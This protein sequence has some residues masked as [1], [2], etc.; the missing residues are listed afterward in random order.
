MAFQIPE[1]K[2][3]IKQNRFEFTLP[4]GTTASMPKAKYLTIGQVERLSKLGTEMALT[5]MLELFEE[6][7]ALEAVRTL[8]GEQLQALME[9]WQVDSGISV[10]ESSASEQNS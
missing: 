3:S 2:R 4:D 7:D 6:P 8:D 10:G 5:D 9:A 1:S